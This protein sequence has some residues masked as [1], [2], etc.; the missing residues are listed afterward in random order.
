MLT[1]CGFLDAVRGI[2]ETQLAVIDDAW[3]FSDGALSLD[4]S[5]LPELADLGGAVRI[6]GVTLVDPILV[7]LGEDSNYYAFKN[8]CTHAGRMIDPVAGTMTL[9]CCSVSGSTYDYQGNVI[10]GPAEGKLTGYPLELEAS[11]LAIRL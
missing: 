5:K 3:S 8:A 2:P 7:V 10:S 11:Q 9:E 4:L 1:S 6:E